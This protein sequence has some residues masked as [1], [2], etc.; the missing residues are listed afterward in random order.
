[1][2]RLSHVH[3]LCLCGF[4][5]PTENFGPSCSDSRTYRRLRTNIAPAQ[6]RLRENGTGAVLTLNENLLG[7]FANSLRISPCAQIK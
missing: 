1:M 2:I 6:L 4:P 3:Q 7:L 5:G